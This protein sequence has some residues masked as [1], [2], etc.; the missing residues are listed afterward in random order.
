MSMASTVALRPL[1]DLRWSKPDGMDG[2]RR[3][4]PV[5]FGLLVTDGEH[6][7]KGRQFTDHTVGIQVSGS[8]DNLGAAIGPLDHD[9][10]VGAIRHILSD[11]RTAP[12]RPLAHWVGLTARPRFRCVPGKE[13]ADSDPGDVP[14]SIILLRL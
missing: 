11:E 1:F 2:Y 10:A 6:V 7:A 14:L 8:T 3:R 4:R 12:P 9:P 13:Q 5:P